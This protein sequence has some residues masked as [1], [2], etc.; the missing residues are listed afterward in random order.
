MT[1][2]VHSLRNRPPASIDRLVALTAPGLTAVN[3][4]IID[5]MQSPVALIP[6]LAG[7]LIAGG[8]KRLRP[9][10]T[11]G[12]AALLEY[13]G[14]RHHKLAAAVEFIHTATLLHDDVVDASGLRRG[15]ATANRL[16]GNPASVLVGD[17][18]FSRSFELM[19]EDGS[20]KVLKILSHASA[21]IAEGEV[22]QLTAQRN[23]ETGEDR[24]LE[25]ITAKTAAL[26]AAACQIAAIVAERDASVEA[27][28][29]AYG[30]NLGIAF[31]LVDD[32]IDYVSD[33]DT[34]GKDSGDDFRDGKIT[35]PVILAYARGSEDQRNF[36]REAMSGRAVADADL[37]KAR[38]LLL[39]SRAVEDTMARARMYGAKAI[40]AI[41]GFPNGLAKTALVET[42]E[43]AIA[44]AY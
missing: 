13:G 30:R 44:R 9:M 43:F 39:E 16:W 35:L 5:R 18:L 20:L 19:V 14:A 28:L 42:V 4:V 1:A 23:V 25:I 26:F 27:A 17:F 34:M 2:T 32:A 12:C 37:A 3:H 41:S 33:A 11:L 36:W 10:L 31:Q 29:Q 22:A 8:G 24:Y 6:E 38:T 15:K 21:I 40:D 7:H